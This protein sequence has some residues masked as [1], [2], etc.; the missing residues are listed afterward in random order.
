MR[1]LDDLASKYLQPA[2][3]EIEN[4]LIMNWYPKRVALRTGPVK[5]CLELGLGHGYTIQYFQGLAEEHVVIEGSRLVIDHFVKAN[6]WFS[7]EI[8]EG[9]FETSEPKG[10]FD[11]ILMGFVLEHVEDPVAIMRRYRN[12][13]AKGGRLFVAVPNAK[14]MNRRL[15]F[16][17]G[18]ISDIYALNDNDRSLGHLRN[19]CLETLA[20]DAHAAGYQ[21]GHEEGVYL[22]PLPLGVLKTL[23]KLDANLDA[24][25]KVGVEYPDLCVAI[26]VELI[27]QSHD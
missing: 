20:A 12:F 10:L 4:D 3:V 25:L 24:M 1:N 5:R 2:D 18:L 22:K 17:M 15:G 6:S 11:L 26:L 16:E 13:L 8:I 7:G 19:Y 14:S 21:I 27:P 9:Y 23:D